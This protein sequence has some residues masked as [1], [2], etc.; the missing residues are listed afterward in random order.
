LTGTNVIAIWSIGKERKGQDRTGYD[1]VEIEVRGGRTSVYSYV[2]YLRAEV[3]DAIKVRGSLEPL[4]LFTRRENE[5]CMG[6]SEIV[7]SSFKGREQQY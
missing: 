3:V 7:I 2:I 6:A 5:C 4:P 1:A